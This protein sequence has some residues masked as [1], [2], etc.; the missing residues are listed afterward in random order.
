MHFKFLR[1]GIRK[2]LL[3]IVWFVLGHKSSGVLITKKRRIMLSYI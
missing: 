3:S 2:K 1:H